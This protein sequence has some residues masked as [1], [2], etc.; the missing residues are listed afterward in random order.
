MAI[1]PFTLDFV[2]MLIALGLP[3]INVIRTGRFAQG[4]FMTWGLL[5]CWAVLHQSGALACGDKEVAYEMGDAPW[6]V[7]ALAL[8]WIHGIIVSGVGM[9]L[10]YFISKL[11]HRANI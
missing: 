10:R 5:V 6:A 7:P 9:G 2:C 11:K 3:L 4:V 1:L 8:G